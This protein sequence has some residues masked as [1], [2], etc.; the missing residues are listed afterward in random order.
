ME[1]SNSRPRLLKILSK[2]SPR[3][4]GAAL[5]AL[6][7]FARLCLPG[8]A[9]AG[10]LGSGEDLVKANMGL[11]SSRYSSSVYAYLDYK[12]EDS[13]DKAYKRRYARDHLP[14]VPGLATVWE[15]LSGETAT[16]YR[17]LA[18]ADAASADILAFSFVASFDLAKF[19]AQNPG[20]RTSYTDFEAAYKKRVQ[21]RRNFDLETLKANNVEAKASVNTRMPDML[22]LHLSSI[23]TVGYRQGLQAGS[24]TA[25]FMNQGIV[26]LRMDMQRQL[27]METFFALDEMREDSD[28]RAAFGGGIKWQS[29]NSGKDY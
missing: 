22:K 17:N 26:L 2:K 27:E 1:K 12:E 5:W 11:V 7:V 15:D 3:A 14:L 13:A 28:G 24:Q 9:D 18:S 19:E 21:R 6:A 10:N 20:Y 23:A 8:A 29:Q 25:N 16:L 4:A